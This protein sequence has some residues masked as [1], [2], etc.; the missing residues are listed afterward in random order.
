LSLPLLIAF[1]LAACKRKQHF[2]RTKEVVYGR[3][4]G[5]ALT[6]DVIKPLRQNRAAVLWIVSGGWYSERPVVESNDLIQ[7]FLNRGYTVFMVVHG[8]VPRYS[9]PPMVDDLQRAVRFIRKNADQFGIDPD[10]IAVNGASSGGHL[11]LLLATRPAPGDPTAKD[12]VETEPAKVRAVAAVAPPTDFLNYGEPGKQAETTILKPF[13][14]GFAFEEIG[15]DGNFTRITDK[16]KRT[17][18]FKQISPINQVSPGDAATLIFHGDA[19]QVVPLEQSTRLLDKFKQYSIPCKLIIEKGKGHNFSS[20]V[21]YLEMMEQAADWF[22]IH[23]RS[24]FKSSQVQ[25]KGAREM[26]PK[27]RSGP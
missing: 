6:M 16:A 21:E 22:D 18:I 17:E 4:F 11:A 7:P 15:A 25:K 24:S 1:P 14:T 26:K 5:T 20:I 2:S 27:E 12:P 9:V 10:K 8:S 23:V 13:A 3:K 19:D